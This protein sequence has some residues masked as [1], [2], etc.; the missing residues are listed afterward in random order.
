MA[1]LFYSCCTAQ[2]F[3]ENSGERSRMFRRLDHEEREE[4]KKTRKGDVEEGEEGEE[5][6]GWECRV[7]PLTVATDRFNWVLL[8]PRTFTAWRVSD[9][10]LPGLAV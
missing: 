5:G 7:P 1:G 2:N 6:E 8:R 4:K 10:T 3:L 9:C